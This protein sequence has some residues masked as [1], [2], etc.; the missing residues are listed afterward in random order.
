MVQ[1]LD[2]NTTDKK[3]TPN[4]APTTSTKISNKES[5]HNTN[6]GKAVS[7]VID[8]SGLPKLR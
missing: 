3:T 5:T 8:P 1:N 6:T 2:K 7:R 4:Q